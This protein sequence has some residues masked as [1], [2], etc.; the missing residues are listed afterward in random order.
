MFT[1]CSHE[2]PQHSAG[3][4]RIHITSSI[5]ALVAMLSK[6]SVQGGMGVRTGSGGLAS[7]AQADSALSN[8]DSGQGFS[9]RYADI[10][11]MSGI[12]SS[13]TSRGAS[14]MPREMPEFAVDTDN[15]QYM[16]IIGVG[17]RPLTKLPKTNLEKIEPPPG[18]T[19]V[20]TYLWELAMY[21]EGIAIC[22]EHLPLL[23]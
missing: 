16:T 10:E 2:Q 22:Y 8:S 4:R 9:L 15:V 7:S 20:E 23:E 6:I 5:L 12:T 1:H 21:L 19:Y 14:C 11:Y 18:M 3:L 17:K 13:V